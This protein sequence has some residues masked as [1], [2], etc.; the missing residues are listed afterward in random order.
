MEKHIFKEELIA[1][2][3][4]YC[5]VCIGYLRNKKPC[6]GCNIN[7]DNKP[8]HC[9]KCIISNCEYLNETNTRLCFNCIKFPCKR[10]KQLDARY[11]KNYN[12]SLIANLKDI[13]TRGIKLFLINEEIKWTC[14][15][16]GKIRSIHKK[17]CTECNNPVVNL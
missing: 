3:G 6:A 14:P 15:H 4:I 2:C 7:N 11:R 13:Q 17:E 9:T 12:V 16:C 8:K 1:P 10:L 5:G